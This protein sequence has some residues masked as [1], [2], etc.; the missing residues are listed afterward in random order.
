VSVVV[1]IS[2]YLSIIAILNPPSRLLALTSEMLSTVVTPRITSIL[3]QIAT[4]CNVPIGDIEDAYPATDLQAAQFA[5][6]TVSPRQLYIDFVF[7]LSEEVARD[8]QRLRRT[9]NSVYQRNATLRSRIVRYDDGEGKEARVA[10]A[11]IR[12]EL[13]WTEFTDLDT[14]CKSSIGDVVNYGDNINSF[15]L[16]AD[17]KHFVWT[18]HHALY[19]GWSLALLWKEIYATWLNGGESGSLPERP[20]FSRLVRF[21]KQPASGDSTEYWKKHL[22]GYKGPVFPAYDREPKH[23]V[24]I[25]GEIRHSL[26]PNH[27]LSISARLQTAWLCTLIAFSDTTDILLLMAST[28]RNCPVPGVDELIGLCICGIPLRIQADMDATLRSMI[29]K[30]Q[31]T[32]RDSIEHEHSGFS[33][34]LSQVEESRRPP[35]IFNLKVGEM[36]RWDFPGMQYQESKEFM[37]SP[38]SWEMN[39]TMDGD[40]VS[41]DLAADSTRVGQENIKFMGDR[42][43]KL[44]RISL[45]IEGDLETKVGDVAKR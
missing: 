22:S 6:T 35:H 18:I 43:S 26:P 15:A 37:P 14:Y 25:E 33:S 34:F 9:F 30:V 24:R 7:K 5:I 20:M 11:V 10:L 12:Q 40:L 38:N 19:D 31:Q 21:I 2:T 39:M 17:R 8:V 27:A 23:D 13:P 1:G 28:G 29:G 32:H 44:L 3:G 16:A 45:S 4:Q 36:E 41:W 42:F